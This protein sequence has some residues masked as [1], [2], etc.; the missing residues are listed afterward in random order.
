MGLEQAYKLNGNNLQNPV[1]I[2]ATADLRYTDNHVDVPIFHLHGTPYSPCPSPIVIT[3]ADYTRY[4]EHRKMIWDRLKSDSATSTMLYI[5][6]SG[7]DAN[8]QL[9]IEEVAREFLP[10]KPPMAYRIDPY[11]DPIDIEIHRE[12][13]RVETLVMSLPEFHALVQNELGDNRPS[14]DT[15][16]YRNSVPNTFATNTTNHRLQCSVC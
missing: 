16:K 2:S 1:P 15:N 10:S 8:W 7:R 6:Y 5:G 13:R 11:A 9:I 12:V 3:Q 4:Q 14:V